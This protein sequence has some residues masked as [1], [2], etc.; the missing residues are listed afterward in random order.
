MITLHWLL[1]I[2]INSIQ[3]SK[4]MVTKVRKNKKE[5]KKDEKSKNFII[6]VGL[7]LV[8]PFNGD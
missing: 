2:R 6:S 8:V 3:H 7:F 5:G 4:H 1:I